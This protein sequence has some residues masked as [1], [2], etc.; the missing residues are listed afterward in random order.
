MILETKL[1]PPSLKP[2]TLKRDRLIKLLK[3]NLERKLVV[4]TGD[5]GYG[6]TTLLAQVMKEEGLPCVYY[7]LDRG[8][9][10]LV[11]FASYLVHGLE[12]QQKS[13]AS[14]T[15]GL[16]D[17][18]GEVGKNYEL[19]L[20]TLINE[21]VEK[22]KEELFFILDDYHALPDDSL[23][24]KALDYFIDHLPV[25]VH[26]IVASRTMPPLPSLA[27]WRA[28]EDLFELS[29]E[30]LKFTEEEVKALLSE[31]YKLVL[32]EEE[33]KRVSEQTE[34]WI[35][36]IRLVLQSAGKDGKTIKETL[37]GYLEA[38]QPLFEYFANEIV[39]NEPLEVQ[40]F[41]R[42][43]SILVIMTPEACDSILGVKDDGE[44]QKEYGVIR[45]SEVSGSERLFKGLEKRNLFLTQVGKGEYKYHRLFREYLV[46]QIKDEV[47]R[48][49]LHL[50]AADY[51]QR[52]GELEQAIEHYLEAGSYEWAGRIVVQVADDMVDN[53]RFITLKNW[54]RQIPEEIFTQQP[55]L[56]IAKGKVL[57]E[58]GELDQAEAV[59][60]RAMGLFKALGDTIAL[61][62][63][64][65]Q[66]GFLLWIK[67][68][69]RKA[70]A[71]LTKALQTCPDRPGTPNGPSI[72]RLRSSVFL[73]M[74]VLWMELGD[75]KKGK[76]Y[77]SRAKA[78]GEQWLD[79]TDLI[80]LEGNF[81]ALLVQQG[82]LRRAHESYRAL[83]DRIEDR[84]F[85]GVGTIF[86]NA[87]MTALHL[88]E[89]EW[90]KKFLDRGTAL[91]QPF[92]DSM[93][94]LPL[95][96]RWG[97][98][99]M[100]LEQWDL[101]RKQLETAKE[102]YEKASGSKGTFIVLLDQSRLSR[103]EGKLEEAQRLLQQAGGAVA[104]EGSPLATSL[105]A[106]QGFLEAARKKFKE[107]EQTGRRCLSLAQRFGRGRQ[108]FL[109]LLA[110][111]EARMGL[112]KGPGASRILLQAVRLSKLKGY[113][114]I[115][116]QELRHSPRL[117]DLT[118][119]VA[120]STRTEAP[121]S[122]YLGKILTRC[123]GISAAKGGEPVLFVRLLGKFELRGEGGVRII[124]LRWQM[125]KAIFAYFLLHPEP[126]ATW[127]EIASWAWPKSPPRTARQMLKNALYELRSAL[128]RNAPALKSAIL[129]Q[130]G[131]YILNPDAPLGVDVWEFND[132]MRRAAS[133]VE[134]EEKIAWL[135][136]A[137][138]LYQGPLLSGF[139]H[140]WADSL[141]NALEERYAQ[142]LGSLAKWYAERE[143]HDKSIAWCLKYLELDELDE[144]IHRLLLTGYI[145]L[146]RKDRALKH[147]EQLKK[148]L[149]KELKA[150]PSPETAALVAL[151]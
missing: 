135:E 27:K 123:L 59:F 138:A 141:R 102:H 108:E 37:N 45:E 63:I 77:L 99:Y 145:R 16:L 124:R 82:E 109:A 94:R 12:K 67:G 117:L 85:L 71:F 32:S 101:A 44:F 4:V 76:A 96:H 48:K 78:L 7:D 100:Q 18:G 73:Q 72:E 23:V 58:E 50:R 143:E 79:F 131:R 46:S 64:Q 90:A 122:G 149:R 2:N 103:Y 93:S 146:G 8:D 86:S 95:L 56:L 89:T 83:T 128:G 41:L 132:L 13:L 28:K 88:G 21:L 15:K 62:T 17:Q 139:Y 113:D 38:N 43:S 40:N 22:R 91:C 55:R 53:A 114:G 127:E 110:L 49:S 80:T 104:L 20:G 115:L 30:G 147:Y 65:Y 136:K 31:V 75:Q 54:F 87:A 74:G 3:N 36:G 9:S 125:P 134:G 57:R 33:I 51:Y 35:T 105:L 5:A 42:K 148:I 144:A 26:V 19:L 98:Y 1:Q 14:R 119:R 6:K 34:G 84:Y 106:E 29:R 129:Y 118:R 39:A 61:A 97:A 111:T 137:A 151:L 47:Y 60:V 126:G 25:I 150:E 112:G 70:I 11:V 116:I 69:Y 130:N 121:L 24:H 10:D 140:S 81:A 107:A 133:A 52:M 66:I 68:A 120:R 142:A 92:E